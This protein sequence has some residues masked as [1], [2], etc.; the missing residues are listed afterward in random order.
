MSHRKAHP[1]GKRPP[2]T[3]KEVE[4]MRDMKAE[5]LSLKDIGRIMGTSSDMVWKLTRAVA[6]AAG[7]T[8]PVRVQAG[9]PN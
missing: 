8:R 5:G 6:A 7:R 3:E 9:V 2:F 1:G 4:R